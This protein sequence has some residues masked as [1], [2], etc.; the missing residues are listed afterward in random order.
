MDVYVLWHADYD[1]CFVI[2]VF[3]SE[4]AAEA[5]RKKSK[6]KAQNCSIEVF[7]LDKA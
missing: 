7:T 1:D 4:A 3:T 2:G 6:Y 5:A